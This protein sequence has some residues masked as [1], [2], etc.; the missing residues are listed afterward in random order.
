M[1]GTALLTQLQTAHALAV[2][3]YTDDLGDVP[4]LADLPEPGTITAEERIESIDAVKWTL[5]NGITVLAK[6]TDFR[7]DEVLFR[8]FSPGGHSLVTDE[9]HQSALYA[10]QLIVGSGVGSHDKV[11]LDK[12]LA[13]KRVEVTP[14]IEELFEGFSGSASPEDL[15]TLFQLIMLYATEHRLDPDFF[16]RYEARLRSVA[17][18]RAADRTRSSSTTRTPC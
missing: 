16:T 5:S 2:E 15:E 10:A 9:E 3:P 17:E 13:G 7:D 14:Y 4:L 12:L 6:Q 18:F 11:T 1:L 8:A